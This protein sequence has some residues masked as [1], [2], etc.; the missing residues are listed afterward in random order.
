[1]SKGENVKEFFLRLAS[2]LFNRAI[3]LEIH[4]HAI[5]KSSTPST[6]D[7]MPSMRDKM[8]SYTGDEAQI[9]LRYDTNSP[10]A[11]PKQRN[12]GGGLK[13]LQVRLS[14]NCYLDKSS[15]L[16]HKCSCN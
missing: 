8:S 7:N 2:L 16:S 4:Q 5:T 14:Q 6:I 3:K 10:S 12:V 15:N 9:T 13:A 11:R 1:M